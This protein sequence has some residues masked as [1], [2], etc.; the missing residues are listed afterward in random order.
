LL[1]AES[2]GPHYALDELARDLGSPLCG[3]HTS[4]Q[5]LQQFL[6]THGYVTLT[7]EGAP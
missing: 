7:K 1:T 2:R 6:A 4:R 5:A 3:L